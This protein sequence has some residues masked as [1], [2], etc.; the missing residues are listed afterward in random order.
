MR[1]I[2]SVLGIFRNLCALL[3]FA[4]IAYF[5][6]DEIKHQYVKI[7]WEPNTTAVHGVSIG[8]SKSDV[9]FKKGL[10]YQNLGKIYSYGGQVDAP[11]T[12]FVVIF[13][14]YDSVSSLIDNNGW[15]ETNF[16]VPFNTVEEMKEILGEED[17]LSISEDFTQRR[18]T[19]LKW[20]ITYDFVLNAV[21]KYTIG[22][23]VWRQAEN[24]EEYIVKGRVVCP[25]DDCP[26]DDKG[27]LKPEYQAKD[28]TMFLPDR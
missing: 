10:P 2:K 21:S 15:H 4:G 14:E 1:E 16:K 7:S 18:Y 26:W 24:V 19:Y 12:E 9:V 13:N 27:A 11:A 3:I 6:W 22:E 8:D 23:I 5:Y 20:N 17:L 25:S 28:Y